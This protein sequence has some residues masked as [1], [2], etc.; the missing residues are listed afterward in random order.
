M[1]KIRR[2]QK[3]WDYDPEKG[4]V[5]YNKRDF[6]EFWEGRAMEL[7][8]AEEQVIIRKLLPDTGGWFL[9]LGCGF[10]RLLPD[11]DA[12]DRNLVLVDYALNHLEMADQRY[13]GENVHFVAADA[14][15]LP[16][17][18]GVFS[19]GVCVRFFHH[20]A[21]PDPLWA[22]LSRIFRPAGS[23]VFSYVNQ[24]NLL[25][26]LLHGKKTMSQDHREIDSQ[27]FACHPQYFDNL[28]NR[29]GFHL[30]GLKGTGLLYQ[31]THN[32][33]FLKRVCME[34]SPLAARLLDFLCQTIDNGLNPFRLCQMQ[35]ALLRR[36]MQDSETD[37][38]ST[39]RLR[40]ILLCPK[41]RNLELIEEPES[42]ICSACSA[43]YPR[44]GRIVDFR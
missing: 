44:K 43:R 21:E 41:C 32:N 23:L 4:I 42:F 31:I 22:E 27:I 33:S 25:R 13:K 8:H 17:R 1:V 15:A 16:F 5:D 9:D 7:I 29:F 11:Y 20:V 38:T 34:N 3:L 6:R 35:F 24:R 10:G 12:P 40:D 14:M 30:E 18:E 37:F 2:E 26:I 28:V 19:N 36:E 39:K